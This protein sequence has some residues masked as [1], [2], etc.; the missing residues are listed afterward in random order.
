MGYDGAGKR[1]LDLVI[2]GASLVV[3]APVLVMLGLF[4]RLED[5]GP[6]LFRQERVGRRGARFTVLKF[7]SMPVTSANLPSAAA[8]GLRVTRVGRF[9][10][11]TNLD[12]LPQLLNILVGDMSLVGPRPALPAQEALLAMRAE[13]GADR[14]RPGLTGLAQV[15]SYD[16]MPEA[17]KAA[18]DGQYAARVSLLG[19]LV[20]IL[21]TFRYLLSPP[22]TY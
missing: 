15:S 14:V 20:I 22:P 1:V 18:L 5:G 3:L 21:R 10:R 19:D 11:R 16:Q 13:N 8:G 12:E 4:V 2:G 7:R 9:I 6:A 17:E